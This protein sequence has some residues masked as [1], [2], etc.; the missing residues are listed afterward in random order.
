MMK[1]IPLAQTVQMEGDT[2]IAT[3][4][5]ASEICETVLTEDETGHDEIVQSPN[6]TV[7]EDP[8]TRMPDEDI[9][10]P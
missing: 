5:S 8:T 7:I 9:T 6:R 10:S 3:G 4:D 1:K 2:T